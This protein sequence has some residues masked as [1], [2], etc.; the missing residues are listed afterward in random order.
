VITAV[1][2]QGDLI[3]EVASSKLSYQGVRVGSIRTLIYLALFPMGDISATELTEKMGQV[4]STTTN[5]LTELVNLGIV[6]RIIDPITEK[7]TNPTYLYTISPV[8]D[9]MEVCSI[10][11][12]ILP[13]E[14]ALLKEWLKKSEPAEIMPEPTP[15]SV[16]FE[17]SIATLVTSMSRKISELTQRIEELESTHNHPVEPPSMPDLSE[18]FGLL[19]N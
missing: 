3:T 19:R 17:H 7:R 2:P 13:E 8:V 4:R 12:G 18:A 11:V 5:Q 1:A 10:F 16:N 6:T 15:E 14:V 9:L